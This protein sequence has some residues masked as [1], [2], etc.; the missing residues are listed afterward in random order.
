MY[1]FNLQQVSYLHT[2]NA[3]T[4]IK[5]SI[6][7][8]HMYYF[9]LFYLCLSWR[10]SRFGIVDEDPCGQQLHNIFSLPVPN[11]KTISRTSSL[12]MFRRR[13]L[14]SVPNL[15]NLTCHTGV[16]SRSWQG[17]KVAGSEE[18]QRQKYHPECVK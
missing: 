15:G 10:D 7:F 9:L 12:L 4:E 18:P 8:P 5:N 1:F 13:K 6:L 14:P 3:Y 16:I 11:P 2:Y 17:A